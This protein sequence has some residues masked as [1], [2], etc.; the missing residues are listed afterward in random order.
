MERRMADDTKIKQMPSS[1]SLWMWPRPWLMKPEVLI[2]FSRKGCCLC[3]ALEERLLNIPLTNLDPSVVLKILDID[4]I[5][6]SLDERRLYKNEVP[7][8][9]LDSSKLARRIELPRVSLRLKKDNLFT[10][11]QNKLNNCYQSS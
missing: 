7:V 9:I 2:L 5:E 6:V 11:L 4:T 1:Y 3:E 10:W 8:L